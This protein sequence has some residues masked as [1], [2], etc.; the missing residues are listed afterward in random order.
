[1]ESS[2]GMLAQVCDRNIVGVDEL[3]GETGSGWQV[4]A[5]TSPLFPGLVLTLDQIF[6]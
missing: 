6:E 2:T 5:L 4:Q 3:S 1:M